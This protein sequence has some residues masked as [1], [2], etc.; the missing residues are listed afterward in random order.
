MPR[1]EA[2]ASETTPLLRE[3]SDDEYDAAEMARAAESAF[4][5]ALDPGAS[6][7]NVPTAIEE[8]DGEPARGAAP[9]PPKQERSRAEVF[10]IVRSW[11]TSS[12]ARS[13]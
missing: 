3:S 4:S 8:E 5:L 7:F 12:W 11:P 13:T 1:A 9:A 6:A 10:T 2:G